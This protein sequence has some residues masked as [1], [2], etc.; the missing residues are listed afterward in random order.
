MITGM[1]KDE[2]IKCVAQ[3][4]GITAEQARRAI[5]AMAAVLTVG[6]MSDGKIIWHGFGT[7][8][9]HRRGPRRIH[10]PSTGSMMDIPSKTVIKFRPSSHVL[11]RVRKDRA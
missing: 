7:F 3:E 4:A 5:D 2:Q 9:T 11:E 10:N 1:I 8:A 6:L